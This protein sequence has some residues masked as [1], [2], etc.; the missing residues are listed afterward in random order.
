MLNWYI[1]RSID[2]DHIELAESGEY[3]LSV[4]K[5][6]VRYKYRLYKGDTLIKERTGFVT[7]DQAKRRVEYALN[8]TIEGKKTKRPYFDISTY[9]GCDQ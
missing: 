3:S 8:D 5:I 1:P 2:S 6:Q 7:S 9:G 4:E